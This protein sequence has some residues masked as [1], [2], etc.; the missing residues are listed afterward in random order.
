M[1]SVA[2]AAD[3]IAPIS[4]PQ[5]RALH[6]AEAAA[7]RF[8][9]APKLATWNGIGMLLGAA[10]SLTLALF[11]PPL[12][13]SALVLGG[14]GWVELTAGKQLRAYDPRAPLRLAVNQIVLLALVVSYS[15]VKLH[16]AWSGQASL[17]A[18]LAHHPELSAV[19][20][21][22]DDPAVADT[23]D[24]FGEMYRWGVLAVYS[25][26]IAI[27]LVVQG[28]AAAYYWSRR[29]HVVRFL[30]TTPAWVVDFMR[31]PRPL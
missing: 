24:S 30:E 20:S 25:L 26:L 21:Q 1:S 27:A 14:C 18:E 8:A 9:F 3:P 23:L 19:M 4:E 10:L 31:R 13:F 28:G 22:I 12:L 5:Q 11:D 2:A 29:K 17:A 15:A 7:R 6:E 16:A